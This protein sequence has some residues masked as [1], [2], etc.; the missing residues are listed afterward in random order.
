[1]KMSN[2]DS[3]DAQ[4]LKSAI[5]VLRKIRRNYRASI[6]RIRGAEQFLQKQIEGLGYDSEHLYGSTEPFKCP[7][8]P[9]IVGLSRHMPRSYV[10]FFAKG[11]SGWNFHLAPITERPGGGTLI[12]NDE[13]VRLIDAPANVVLYCV[14]TIE[15]RVV[16][17]LE[18][19]AVIAAVCSDD[20]AALTHS[21]PTKNGNPTQGSSNGVMH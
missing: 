14:D 19:V 11:D 12:R 2:L 1:M 15:Q 21:G 17:I 8:E 18:H 16:E 20:E 5:E 4:T 7:P 9:V 6:E 3:M 13:S 10:L